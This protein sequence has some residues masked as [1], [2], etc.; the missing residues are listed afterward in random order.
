M[1]YY[2]IH[3]CSVKQVQATKEPIQSTLSK[4]QCNQTYQVFNKKVKKESSAA[5]VCKDGCTEGDPV[6]STRESKRC[7]CPHCEVFESV[8]T[9][10]I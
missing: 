4:P 6:K 1:L 10:H 7:D 2:I 5:Q 8:R 9:A 3:D